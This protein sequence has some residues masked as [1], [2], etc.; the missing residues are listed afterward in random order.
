MLRHTVSPSVVALIACAVASA[1]GP[2]RVD[3]LGDPLPDGAITR[4]G[5]TRL[6]QSYDVR[7]LAFSANGNAL[8]TAGLEGTVRLWRIPDGKRLRE[9]N[10]RD[11]KLTFAYSVAVSPDG[12]LVAAVSCGASGE[13]RLHMWDAV[14]GAERFQRDGNGLRPAVAFSPD[15]RL[16]ALAGAPDVLL[17]TATGEELR[18]L[19]DRA[20]SACHVAFSGDGVYVASVSVDE[21]ETTLRGWAVASGKPLPVIWAP[22]GKPFS[23][24][25]AGPGGTVVAGYKDGTACLWDLAGRR[26]VRHIRANDD[27][28]TSLS[29]AG[30]TLLAVVGATGG[31]GLWDLDTGECRRMFVK[32]RPE[33][34]YFVRGNFV[35]AVSPDGRW[36][37]AANSATVRLWDAGTGAERADIAGHPLGVRTCT[38]TADG[39][40]VWTS[41]GEP[42]HPRGDN[43]LRAWD[44]A[45][46]RLVRQ[47]ALPDGEWIRAVSDDAGLAL[48]EVYGEGDVVH[49]WRTAGPERLHALPGHRYGMTRAAF[50]PDNRLLAVGD[51]NS[52]GPTMLGLVHVWDV[53]TGEELHQLAWEQDQSCCYALAFSPGG[54]LLACGG[55][56]GLWLVDPVAGTLLWKSLKPKAYV[57]GLV[58]SGDGRL[59]AAGYED[60]L[61]VYE[62]D[63]GKE[64]YSAPTP[65]RGRSVMFAPDGR[66]LVVASTG[67][68]VKLDRGLV[69]L[70]DMATG[71]TYARFAAHDAAID[72]LAFSRDGRVLATASEDRTVL[73]WDFT[74][75]K[76]PMLA[77]PNGGARQA[78]ADLA[79]DDA[80]TAQRAFWALASDTPAAL[81]LLREQ[82]RPT[83]APDAERLARLIRDLDD[84][85]FDVRERS[86]VALEQLGELATDALREAASKKTSAE[87]RR[88]LRHLLARE[89]PFVVSGENLRSLRAVYL[90]EQIGTADAVAM[91]ERV[92]GGARGSRLTVAAGAALARLRIK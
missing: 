59:L 43:V 2:P 57:Q 40:G 54:R 32:A 75:R 35:A 52:G 12:N 86:T 17:D 46:G 45:S 3:T 67:D 89:Q 39:K 9:W 1:G 23:C 30:D 28:I 60:S 88:R 10:V 69:R 33:L 49:L 74:G 64:V 78:W 72:A 47:V 26:P 90:L 44:A 25:A 53:A 34:N 87:A 16:L 37:A 70:L 6:R 20:P 5:T 14:V 82:L 79:S 58:F 65:R 55:C 71:T 18:R 91:L 63:S 11:F 50:S 84:D 41:C 38:F 73:L 15:G 61:D 36:L 68:R 48:T 56:G 77:R 22:E 8:A 51:T 29:C 27:A 85:D 19:D 42:G 13:V 7:A 66:T 24:L 76:P 31:I 81:L 62:V 92:A 21:N 80:P 83:A 4:I